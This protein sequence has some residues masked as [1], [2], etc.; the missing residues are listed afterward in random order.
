ML[1]I[2]GKRSTM[3]G[4]I[5]QAQAWEAQSLL[6]RHPLSIPT[7]PQL[8]QRSFKEGMILQFC[9]GF[10]GIKI[11]EKK[12]TVYVEQGGHF[13]SDLAAFY[14][15]VSEENTEAFVISRDYAQ[16]L[17]YFIDT[18]AKENKR[19]SYIKG[20]V[21]GPLTFGLSLNGDGG[22][23]VWFDEKYHDVVIKGLKMKAF[24]QI[25]MLKKYADKVVI[26]FDEP[27]LSALSTPVYSGIQEA[28]I[29]A[30]LN[31]L[32]EGIHSYGAIM[33]VHCC[34]NMNWG[35]LAQTNIDII[36]FD[37]YFFGEK[38][39]LY[40]DKIN[41]FLNRGGVLAWGI[42]P[43]SDTGKLQSETAA[44]LNNKL[45]E[46]VLLFTRKGISEDK[47]RAQMLLTPSCGMGSGSLTTDDAELI[48]ELLAELIR[49]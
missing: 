26:F 8:P 15:R 1:K 23:A 37:A 21:T 16:G 10:P 48:L 41:A 33:G 49:V 38:V 34:G 6:N 27:I 46:L 12:K 28:E 20:Q 5:P 4:S 22:K 25:K 43:T 24:W 2:S 11:D 42:V 18:A 35:L 14:E 7:W 40:P 9:E 30:V 47:L 31:E 13:T 39:A 3:M 45:E 44:S 17:Y 19:L 29:L 32:A 36:A